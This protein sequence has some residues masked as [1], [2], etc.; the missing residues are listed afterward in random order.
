MADARA[1]HETVNKL[2]KDYDMLQTI[3]RG[4]LG[5]HHSVFGAVANLVKTKIE[6]DETIVFQVVLEDDDKDY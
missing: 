3:N 2:L 6:N 5:W 1:R 4:Q